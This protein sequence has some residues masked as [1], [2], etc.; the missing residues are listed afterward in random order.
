VPQAKHSQAVPIEPINESRPATR[1]SSCGAPP[2]T[3]RLKAEKMVFDVRSEEKTRLGTDQ[4]MTTS[5]SD[6]SNEAATRNTSEDR[7][8]HDLPSLD[9]NLI[10]NVS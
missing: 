1:S 9:R 7:T 2:H 6:E 8:H 4:T 10:E 5:G 3:R